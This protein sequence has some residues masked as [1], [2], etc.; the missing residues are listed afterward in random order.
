MSRLN[1]NFIGVLWVLLALTLVFSY[2][3]VKLRMSNEA[4][5]KSVMTV[6]DYREFVRS[7]DSANMDLD[8]VLSR[9]QQSGVKTVALNEVTLRDLAYEGYVTISSYGDFS[10]QTRT[11]SPQIWAEVQRVVGSTY[12][13]PSNLT[14]V[15]SDPD[16]ASFLKERLKDRFLPQE[17]ISFEI[18]GKSYF[19]INSQL[20]PIN[21]DTSS[22]DKNKAVS[23]DLDARLGFEENLLSS[24]K[25][26]GFDIILRP[27]QNTGSNTAYEAEYDRLVTAYGVKTIIFAGNDVAGSPDNLDWIEGFINKYH[28]IV[29]I[30]EP[31]TQLQYVKQNGLDA[32]MQATG[33][34]VNRVYSSSNDE[35]GITID[36]RYYRWT[37]AVVDRGIRI[38]YVVPFKDTKLS[39][40]Q[41]LNNTIDMLAKF[42]DTIA[43]KG[44]TVDQLLPNLSG[45]TTGAVHRLMVS[46]SLFLAGT[47]YLLYLFRPKMKAAWMAGWLLLGTIG[48]LGANLVLH[49]DFSKLYALGAAVLYPS[50]SSLLLLLYLKRSREKPLPAQILVSMVIILGVNA[51]GMYT[52]VTSLSDIRYIMNVLIF[53]GVKLAFVVPL[54][55]FLINYVSCMVGF[56]NF[57]DNAISFLL[58]KP[59]YLVLLL[60]MV[61]AAAGYYYLGR[62]GNAVVTVSGLEIRTRE[63]LERIFLA[64]PRFK[65]LLIGYPSLF[66]MVYW[67]KKYKYDAILLVMGMGVMMGSISMVNSFCHV[68]TAVMISINRT[69][70]GLLTGILIGLGAII[71][72]KICEWLI[73][74]LTE[75]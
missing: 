63:V 29:G 25:A 19:I 15:T 69:M 34:S 17:L 9:L 61:G 2:S 74:I 6:I 38:L 8:D 67:Y 5:N 48:C 51:L 40:S 71:A 28:L 36:E 24:L 11:L 43:A 32:V 45:D 42:H 46:L 23:K 4:N 60:L 73:A 68:F 47:I 55:L 70:A 1:K 22:S 75:N 21:T 57:K 41:N 35:Y 10:A 30:I 65:E 44:F 52:V 27:G 37:R 72:V 64:R 39:Y 7:A 62:S 18:E 53:S 12:I 50:L 33:Y 26:K 58:S 20:S 59:N 31:S 56:S 13:S 66:L 16:T 3:G 14:V 49:I 54:L